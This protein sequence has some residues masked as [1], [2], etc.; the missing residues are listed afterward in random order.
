VRVWVSNWVGVGFPTGLAWGFQLGLGFQLGCLGGSNCVSC[1]FQLG[2]LG[3]YLGA[4]G[5]SPLGVLPLKGEG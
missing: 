2:G 4:C 1:G 3:F 5:V